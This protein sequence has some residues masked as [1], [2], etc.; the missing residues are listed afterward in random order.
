MPNDNETQTQGAP[1]ESAERT[2]TQAEVDAIVR[3][4]LKREREKH[5]DYAELQKKAAAYDQ[6]QEA[7]KTELQ[8]AVERAEK[9]EGE[10]SDLRAAQERAELVARLAAEKGVDADMLSRMSGDVADN[11]AWLAEHDAAR[12]KYPTLTDKGE[13]SSSKG[14]EQKDFV[15]S[16]FGGDR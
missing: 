11:A 6:A 16:L 7:S 9:A 3:D 15:R 12:P 5:A 14:G 2:F 4:R 10:L 1:A 8:K 13:V